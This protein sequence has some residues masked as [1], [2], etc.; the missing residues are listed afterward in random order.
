MASETTFD[1]WK[2][3]FS[4]GKVRKT[5]F[6]QKPLNSRFSLFGFFIVWILKD[7]GGEFDVKWKILAQRTTFN[8]TNNS[9]R[10]CLSEK[11][12]IMFQPEIATLNQRDEF[13]TP[14]MHKQ[15][16][17]LD[18]TWPWNFHFCMEPDM[19]CTLDTL[20]NHHLFNWGLWK[21]MKQVVLNFWS[22]WFDFHP[23]IF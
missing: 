5:R 17:L 2:V 4:W 11:F 21:H 3:V 18:K 7:E 22:S 23:D 6:S 1:H 9:C 12:I 8:P 15:N 20:V 10:L 14:C 13:Y 19:T 16:K